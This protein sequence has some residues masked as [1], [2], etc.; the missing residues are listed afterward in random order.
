MYMNMDKVQ[1]E[2]AVQLYTTLSKQNVTM[3]PSQTLILQQLISS[4]F[5]FIIG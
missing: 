2:G 5:T 1:S 3:C 4:L